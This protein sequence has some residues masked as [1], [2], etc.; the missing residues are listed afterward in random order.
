MPIVLVGCSHRSA[1]LAL[2]ESL[3]VTSN[4]LS[5]IFAR[6]K[7]VA[8]EALILST[9]NRTE[10]YALVEH[11]P[12][13]AASLLELFA[14]RAGTSSA[15][16]RPHLYVQ[17]DADAVRQALRVAS[18]LDS[19]VLGE[20]QIQAQLKRALAEARLAQA[21][22]PVLDRLGAAALACGKRV[23]TFTGIGR[24]SVSLESLAVR[25]ASD[26]FG[27]LANREVVL[28]GTGDAARLIARHIGA[29]AGARVTVISRSIEKAAE[30]ARD[31]DARAARIEDLPDVLTRADVVITCTSA[32]H[33]ILT[34][35]DLQL[36]AGVRPGQTLVC[37]D[38]GMPHDVDPA[39]AHRADVTLI[40]LRELAVLA[41]A[42]REERRQH[43]PAAEAIVTAEVHRFL[44]WRGVRGRAA[45]IAR[46]QAHAQSIADAELSIT[47]A[48][49]NTL[50]ARDRD[51]VADLARR[52][53]RK[54][55]HTPSETLQQHP[56]AE[57]IAF[58]L[59]CAFG[60]SGAPPA[61]DHMP[62]HAAAPSASRSAAEAAS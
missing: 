17:M 1:P 5:G 24:H 34:A 19:V 12:S 48:R 46:L 38:L 45:T 33:A 40:S 27:G 11:L 13:G 39:V 56:D 22:G 52:I 15:A 3:S 59:E 43:L 26:R 53:I 28:I 61:A 14:E 20:D 32:P 47:Q 7:A 49:L 58:A 23:R 8:N 51:L 31:I 10:I 2:L 44:E 35:D 6:V 60:L 37:V 30:F 18:G 50:S 55:M 16:L 62:D 29:P 21:L 54:L 57:R 25:A 4:E 41:E 36:R 9:C 42:H